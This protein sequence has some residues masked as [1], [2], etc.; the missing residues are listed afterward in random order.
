MITAKVSY[1]NIC[2]YIYIYIYRYIYILHTHTHIHTRNDRRSVQ[3]DYNNVTSLTPADKITVFEPEPEEAAGA[4]SIGVVVIGVM[5][6]LSV[7]LGISDAPVLLEAMKGR[8]LKR[9]SILHSGR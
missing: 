1:R 4:G 5:A 7:V 9:R 6:L 3:S 8:R 2:L